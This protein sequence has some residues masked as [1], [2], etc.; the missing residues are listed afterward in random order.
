MAR[1]C[2]RKIVGE[3]MQKRLFRLATASV[4]NLAQSKW[5]ALASSSLDGQRP[6]KEIVWIGMER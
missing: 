4:V 3:R 1:C 5:H 6:G 2:M